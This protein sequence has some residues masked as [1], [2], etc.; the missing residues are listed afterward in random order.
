MTTLIK[1]VA[2]H[3]NNI[4]YFFFLK[5]CLTCRVS[6]QLTFF[7]DVGRWATQVA[8]ALV[9]CISFL[10]VLTL[11]TGLL[12]IFI[13]LLQIVSLV[14]LPSLWVS[15]VPGP[16]QKNESQSVTNHQLYV[17]SSLVKSFRHAGAASP[18]TSY[19]WG[20]LSWS[21]R[22]CHRCDS[23]GHWGQLLPQWELQ[24]QR[25]IPGTKTK[26]GKKKKNNHSNSHNKM[27]L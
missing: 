21:D 16:G 3:S 26:L 25:N 17:H 12:L 8:A 24:D 18:H 27:L 2:Y 13:R 5:V 15:P 23:S 7:F 19:A 20:S 22:F 11:V 10:P 6:V 1:P 9:Q 4:K 14:L